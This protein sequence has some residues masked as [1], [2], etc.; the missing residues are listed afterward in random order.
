MPPTQKKFRANDHD[1]VLTFL[2]DAATAV[3]RNLFVADRPYQLRS[4][5]AV[6]ATASS[7]GTLDLKKCSGTTAPGSGTSMCTGTLS[8]AGTANTTVAGT[9]STTAANTL[10]AD[11]DRLAADFG[12]TVTS[13][14]GCAVTIVLRPLDVK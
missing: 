14:A 3:D 13:L 5:E 4:I 1:L 8:L 12:G 11:G 9:L 10:L 6:H 2:F 7:S